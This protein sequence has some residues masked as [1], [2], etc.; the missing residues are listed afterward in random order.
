MAI[1]TLSRVAIT[2]SSRGNHELVTCGNHEL[3]WTH[4][5]NLS[6]LPRVHL[7]EIEAGGGGPVLISQQSEISDV[8]AGVE[9]L[10][11]ALNLVVFELNICLAAA[12]ECRMSGSFCRE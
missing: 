1:K 2:Y 3:V 4:H 12:R 6:R 10:V 7:N 5:L 9:S 8:V 11:F